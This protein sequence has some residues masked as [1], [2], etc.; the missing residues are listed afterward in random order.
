MILANSRWNGRAVSA[1]LK[2][3]TPLARHSPKRSAPAFQGDMIML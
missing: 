3:I 2:S 1:V